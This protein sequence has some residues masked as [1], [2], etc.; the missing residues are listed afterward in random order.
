MKPIALL[1]LVLIAAVTGA[2][3]GGKADEQL[4]DPEAYPGV[5]EDQLYA[6]GYLPGETKP[7][8]RTG[9]IL[10]RE[11][12]PSPGVNLVISP[13]TTGAYLM[14]LEGRILHEWH[15]ALWKSEAIRSAPPEIRKYEGRTFDYWSRV[16]LFENGDLLFVHKGCGL[17]RLD[18][19]SRLQWS[20]WIRAH[21]DL[22]V[23][24]NG[25]IYTLVY[26]E[27][28]EENWPDM[29][30]VKDYL[31]ELDENGAPVR[32]ICIDD[33]IA[34]SGYANLR[35]GHELEYLHSNE[36][37]VLDGAWA[38]RNPVFRKGNVLISCRDLDAFLVLDPAAEQVV[39]AMTGG[40][41]R[42]HGPVLLPETG[43]MLV[44]DN[45]GNE[46]YSRILEVNVFTGEEKT[47][48]QG[49]P[50][51]AFFSAVGGYTQPLPN[52]NLLITESTQ[53][54][55]FEV[56]PDGDRVWEYVNPALPDDDTARVAPLFLVQRLA[57]PAAL[58][59][60]GVAP[61]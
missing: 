50:K 49:Q 43:S 21:H 61:E 20:C 33:A 1:S 22:E 9:V 8:V 13:H 7:A 16:H 15:F 54:A 6:L 32:K 14:T 34:R 41:R 29:T 24:E 2:Q 58:S 28:D 52:G 26:S 57:L 11:G 30:G 44:F 42:Q 31:Y 47:R 19:D 12:R 23:I 53:G 38:D 56:T 48:Y 46:G 59:V 40:W 36:I 55:A 35:R 4:F 45:R 37:V 5:A 10:H 18:R 25:H 27:P 51:R 39:W 17:F 60:T 3:E